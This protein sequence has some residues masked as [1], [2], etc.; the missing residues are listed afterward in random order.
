M[1]EFS[2]VTEKSPVNTADARALKGRVGAAFAAALEMMRQQNPAVLTAEVCTADGFPVASSAN[3]E[4]SSRRLAE[5]VCSLHA[6]GVAVVED[7]ALGKYSH[8]GIDASG[9]K[10]VLFDLPSAGGELVLAATCNESLLWEHFLP[11]CQT[12]SEKLDQL[13]AEHPA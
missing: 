4:E 9:G 7:T 10:C 6:L 13:L 3:D 1:T 2:Q 11:I 5:I 8:L 12:F